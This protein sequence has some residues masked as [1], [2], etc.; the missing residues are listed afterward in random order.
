M[1]VGSTGDP[2]LPANLQS[3][4]PLTI[5]GDS[6]LSAL[7]QYGSLTQNSDG[8]YTFNGNGQ[9]VPTLN[10]NNVDNL[11]VTNSIFAD[12]GPTNGG[13]TIS[14]DSNDVVVSNSTFSGDQYG[15]NVDQTD[16]VNDPTNIGIINNTFSGMVG[17]E[18][19]GSP[20]QF[21]GAGAA[22][23]PAAP[24]GE[25]LIADNTIDGT[26]PAI[27][28]ENGLDLLSIYNYANGANNADTLIYGNSISGS[29][30]LDGGAQ[31]SGAGIIAELDPG[32]DG[33]PTVTA[34]NNFITGQTGSGLGNGGSDADFIGNLI[35]D[36]TGD[37]GLG[38]EGGYNVSGAYTYNK[39]DNSPV[40]P[41]AQN[42]GGWPVLYAPN[43]PPNDPGNTNSWDV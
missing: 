29:L 20:I 3:L 22:G 15:I 16:Y 8:S 24:N 27:G 10:L 32:T 33:T 36:S 13:L 21:L 9:Q 37:V 26:E 1:D 5:N 6:G 42:Q 35:T 11:T 23:I 4:T 30:Q 7:D 2:T 43:G 34:A 41:V 17:S 38:S 25:N 18:P 28:S 12:G 39:T 31:T 14:G 40:V 19:D